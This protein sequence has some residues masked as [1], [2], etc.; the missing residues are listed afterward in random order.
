MVSLFLLQ[1]F[2]TFFALFWFFRLSWT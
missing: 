2:K 1:H